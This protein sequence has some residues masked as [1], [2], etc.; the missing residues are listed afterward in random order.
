MA[1]VDPLVSDRNQDDDGRQ[2]DN[3]GRFVESMS[4]EDVYEYVKASEGGVTSGDVAKEWGTTRETARR[5][6][7]QLKED[8]QVRSQEVGAAKLWTVVYDE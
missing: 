8:G 1:T 2:R 3:S 7:K 5:K 4:L 6:L